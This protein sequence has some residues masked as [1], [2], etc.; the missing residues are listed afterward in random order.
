MKPRLLCKYS[1]NFGFTTIYKDIDT[2]EEAFDL[3]RNYIDRNEYCMKKK[4][5]L[6]ALERW[7]KRAVAVP[8]S[9]F[10]HFYLCGYFG[11]YA[12][13]QTKVRARPWK[14]ARRR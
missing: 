4:H 13:Y 11:N 8:E 7:Q 9:N 10:P 14:P 5:L 1:V 2:M 12:I 6:E 3:M